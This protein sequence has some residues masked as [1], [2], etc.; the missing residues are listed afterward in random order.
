EASEDSGHKVLRPLLASEEKLC[1]TTDPSRAA[2]AAL[3]YELKEPT[4][5]EPGVVRLV[6]KPRRKEVSLV[7]G[8]VFVT[9]DDADLVRVEGRLAKN[10]SFWITSV[11]VVRRYNRLAGIRVPVRLDSTA[12]VRIAGTSTL[13][14]TYDYEMVNG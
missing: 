7:E 4:A 2:L 13:S 3:N 14:V 10:P 1:A 5:R 11:D 12:Q 8:F 6:A 9:G